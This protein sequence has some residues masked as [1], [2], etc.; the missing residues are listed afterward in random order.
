MTVDAFMNFP[1]EGEVDMEVDEAQQEATTADGGTNEAAAVGQVE[2]VAVDVTRTKAEGTDAAAVTQQYW[3]GSPLPF[4]SRTLDN[5]LLL[6]EA[7]AGKGYKCP[8]DSCQKT[9]KNAP[10]GY[11]GRY[12]DFLEH[13]W[14]HHMAVPLV[15]SCGW[16]KC[17]KTYGASKRLVEHMKAH[18][19]DDFD[20]PDPPPC[21]PPC[22]R[23][24]TL[25]QL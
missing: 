2:E 21:R 24:A 13:W 20:M 12:K 25:V 9:N 6:C 19:R 1:I 14:V 10:T 8:A 16:R 17:T 11:P 5:V 15:L 23:G 7:W 4:Q 22:K 3:E 18:L